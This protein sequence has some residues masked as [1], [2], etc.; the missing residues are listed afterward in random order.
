[1]WDKR[2][3]VLAGGEDASNE[4]DKEEVA[5]AVGSL[6]PKEMEVTPE[7]VEPLSQLQNAVIHVVTRATL[8]QEDALVGQILGQTT[9]N[10]TASSTTTN[11]D[12]VVVVDIASGE[13]ASGNGGGGHVE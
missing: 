12:V 11:D 4:E 3:V 8:N 9:G 6:K 1:M 7:Q 13:F 5:P 10:H 2:A